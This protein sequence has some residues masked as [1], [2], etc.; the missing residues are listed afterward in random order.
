MKMT[1]TST[2]IKDESKISGTALTEK[3]SEMVYATVSDVFD[4]LGLYGF[5]ESWH[6][7]SLTSERSAAD[8]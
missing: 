5:I 2:K 6:G 4:K 3:L 1:D 8:C 7:L